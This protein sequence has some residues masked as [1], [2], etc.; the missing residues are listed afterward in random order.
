M[1]I[2]R[3]T[4][5]AFLPQPIFDAV[6]NDPYDKGDADYSITGLMQPPRISALTERHKD[7]ISEDASERIWSLIGQSIHG[8]LERAERTALAEVR[9]Y[10][11]LD[12]VKISGKY[13]RFVILDKC[14]QD[15]KVTSVYRVMRETPIHFTAQ[16]NAYLYLLRKNGYEALSTQL[17]YILRDWHKPTARRDRGDYP[18]YQIVVKDVEVWSEAKT[19][20]M[21]RERIALQL[22]A[23]K[24]LPLCDDEDRWKAGDKWV[25][26]KPGAS[27]AWRTFD[28]EAMAKETMEFAAP[29]Y[30]LL[31]RRAEAKRCLDYCSVRP[32]CKQFKDEQQNGNTVGNAKE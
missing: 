26:K 8:I 18:P 6:T 14:L 24:E 20:A 12:G 19:E 27:R 4:N 22:A 16:Q 9:L 28:N 25:L 2:V 21:L 13:D 17:I 31:V 3:F 5:H 10:A 32:F 15:Y 7:E 30:E 23:R 11:S 1:A 29:G